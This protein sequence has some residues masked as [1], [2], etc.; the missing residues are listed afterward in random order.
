MREKKQC[1]EKNCGQKKSL[2][3]MYRYAVIKQS[4]KLS[5]SCLCSHIPCK[6]RRRWS[7][8]AENEKKETGDRVRWV[9]G[10]GLTFLF[11]R[12]RW[13]RSSRASRGGAIRRPPRVDRPLPYDSFRS[14]PIPPQGGVC[15][16]CFFLGF[17][18]P[19]MHQT[20][21][22]DLI[23]FG[24]FFLGPPFTSPLESRARGK[25]VFFRVRIVVYIS[26]SS[27]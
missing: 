23:L 27:N 13:L 5:T 8:S 2:V 17:Y 26:L 3:I 22:F 20:R 15:L 21:K 7:R 10:L 1:Y 16:Q 19:P 12:W 24:V 18:F 14:T 9:G 4:D 25:T 6:K 11:F